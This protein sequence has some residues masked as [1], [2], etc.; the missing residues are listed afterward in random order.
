MNYSIISIIGIVLG[1]IVN[2]DI[3]RKETD[4]QKKHVHDVYR[5]FLICVFGY[6]ITD[7]LWGF[8]YS[9]KL[10]RLLYIDTTVYFLFM[11]LSVLMWTR[12]VTEYLESSRRFRRMLLISGWIFMFFE[13]SAIVV[14]F[15]NPILFYFDSD[16]VYHAGSA[17]HLTLIFQIVMF[18]ITTLYT[19]YVAAITD[20]RVMKLRYRAVWVFG[21]VMI[22]MIALQLSNPILPIYATG[23]LIGI[24]FIHTFVHE[25]EKEE[26]R[27]T[28]DRMLSI[29]KKQ[30]KEIREAKN[31]AYTDSLTGAKNN[32]SYI[33]AEDDIDAR[34]AN[35]T[36][37]DFA[38]AVFDLNG[39][40]IINDTK[41]HEAGDKY[42]VDAV[43][44]IR[45]YFPDCPL[46][47]IG[48]D[49]FVLF[50][51]GENCKNRNKMLEDFNRRIEENV[52]S[53][54]VVIAVGMDKYRPEMDFSY[55]RLF[56]RADKRMYDRKL[57]LKEMSFNVNRNEKGHF[58]TQ[59]YPDNDLTRRV[60]FDRLTELPSMIAF[61]SNAEQ[62]EE[63]MYRI[64]RNPVILYVDLSG[65]RYY[66]QKKGFAKGTQAI[67]TLANLLAGKYG[68]LNCSRFSGDHFAVITDDEL[69]E[70]KLGEIIEEWESTK[71]SYA[72][73]IRIGVYLRTRRDEDI[74]T[75]CD[76]AKHACDFDKNSSESYY[77]FFDENMLAEF[78]NKQYILD[79]FER[80]L[81]EKW[82]QVF[83][84]P[85]VRTVNGRV[86]DEEALARWID[87]EK[88]M[89]TPDQFI[90]ILEDEG[91]I[92]KLD[93]Y[94]LE[95]VLRK[96]SLTR[97]NN[98]H[99]VPQS[100]NIS[101]NDF[102]SCD[103]IEEICRRVDD[104]GFDHSLIN[105]EITESTIAKDPEYMK[106]R[107]DRL[108]ELGFSV[109]MDDFGT[110]YSSL[111]VLQS[112]EF[113]LLKFD[114]HFMRSFND[115]NR[116]RVILTEL[117]KMASAIGIETLCE[118]VER[119]DQLEFLSEAGC[120]KVQG[121][122][123]C[124]PIPAEQVF[125]RYEKGLQI[126]FE[127]P[128]ESQYYDAVGNISL[129]DI[130]F[131][132]SQ[133]PDDFTRYFNTM[134]M[135]IIE[136]DNN[137]ARLIRKNKSFREFMA[138]YFDYELNGGIDEMSEM[139]NGDAKRFIEAIEK[140]C[141]GDNLVFVDEKLAD[142]VLVHSLIRK[143]SRNSQT[144]TEAYALV[145]LAIAE[146][147]G[148]ITYENI[149][150]SLASDYFNLYYVDLRN[151][152]FIEFS[153]VADRNEATVERH[154]K[155]FFRVSAE[156]AKNAI[157]EADREMFLTSFTKENIL[158]A[159]GKQGS[160][161]LGY[162]LMVNGNPV[163]VSMKSVRMQTDP[164][165]IIIGVSNV[166]TQTRTKKVLDTIRNER[167]AY[168][169]INALLG[170]FVVL[171]SIDPSSGHYIETNSTDDFRKLGIS[172]GGDDF[173]KDSAKNCEEAIY[174]DDREF[175][176]S[177]MR[178]ETILDAIKREGLFTIKYRMLINGEPKQVK[179]RAALVTETEGERLII[180]V[181]FIK[182]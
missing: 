182:D 131:S 11:A 51:E 61:F 119:E 146:H 159:I 104:A 129:Y 124:R 26:H 42:I 106:Q 166:D 39:L 2:Y 55:L 20:D 43:N 32:R 49:E 40:K 114:Q 66:N 65:M 53:G 181:N 142:N 4:A 158:E 134:P 27:K 30:R 29:E 153:S 180:G 122:Y 80:A 172:D 76:R 174:E 75:S 19:L 164:D 58:E 95:E 48:G 155:D 101:R 127:N 140:Y 15:F 144:G 34:M 128:L 160:F 102:Y 60:S 141:G 103:M 97:E 50:M 73:A 83:Y 8:L 16:G 84:Q 72:P 110:G 167:I 121:F 117:L 13:V 24:T 105:I 37:N 3:L 149:A 108:R 6:Y 10:L 115:G 56:D 33:E 151:D 152:E 136:L 7:S 126:G 96:L 150:R 1:I 123:F 133:N 109:W 179:L 31:M 67:K 100:V 173:F 145:I 175:F 9:M 46:Y 113:D 74:S 79:N 92:Y 139:P 98:L 21:V 87:P 177:M 90:S 12:Y 94:V 52:K 23:Y 68:I 28:L 130:S 137:K 148:G 91:V 78:Q 25:D 54:D 169:R 170:D 112:I 163:Y 64:G 156:D 45:E 111:N 44:L 70:E 18:A 132:A 147:D 135:T 176:R 107:V 99:L 161:N 36:I 171:Y 41:G 89:I 22:V 125:E 165:H 69:L 82:I 71:D 57:E 93:L 178:K 63:E 47:R 81:E 168:N 120:S 118:G 157:Y 14:N 162:R 17:R 116:S 88:G 85:I 154:G 5:N 38:V 62:A 35:N 86:C 143:I 77:R 138:R 59:N